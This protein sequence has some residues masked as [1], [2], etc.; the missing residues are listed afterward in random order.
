MYFNKSS[1]IGFSFALALT[2]V[3]CQ[4]NTNIITVKPSPSVSSNPNTESI[5]NLSKEFTSLSTDVLSNSFL[6]NDPNAVPSVQPT[7]S[8]VPTSPSPSSSVSSGSTTDI[9]SLVTLNGTVYNQD[10]IT[11]DNVI[12]SAVSLDPNIKWSSEDKTIGGVY[13]FKN[14]PVGIRVEIT[15]KKGNSIRKK[16]ETLKSNL[17][18]DPSLNKIDF[19]NEY[20]LGVLKLEGSVYDA[21]NKIITS[22]VEVT[23]E[24]LDS[25]NDWTGTATFS[26]GRYTFSEVPDDVR[27]M[28]KVKSGDKE[29]SRIVSFADGKPLYVVNFGG[30]NAEDRVYALANQSDLSAGV[31]LF[32]D[33]KQ[34]NSSS[35]S[36]NVKSDSYYYMKKL[37]NLGTLPSKKDV[38]IEEYINHFDYNY[39]EPN[40]GDSMSLNTE[41]SDSPFGGSG[42]RI[43]RVGVKTK[44]LAA[45]K[46]SNIT[47][48]VDT[49]GSMSEKNKD[50]IIKLS[51]KEAISN[52]SSN[53]KFSIIT[54]DSSSNVLVD[55]LDLSNKDS[56]FDKI[57]NLNFSGNTNAQS[58]IEKALEVSKKNYN[59]DSLNRIILISDGLEDKELQNKNEV[60]N[61]LKDN[62]LNISL[63]TLAILSD[64]KSDLLESVAKSSKGHYSYS[65]TSNEL[66]SNIL[67]NIYDSENIAVRDSNI[68]VNF[69]SSVVKQFRLI[70][71]ENHSTNQSGEPVA[72]SLRNNYSS[73]ALYEIVLNEN[74]TDT[75]IVDVLLSYKDSS[76]KTIKNTIYNTQVRPFNSTSYDF[77]LAVTAGLYAEILRGSYWNLTT[78]LNKVSELSEGLLKESNDNYKVKDFVNLVKKAN[79]L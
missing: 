9:S 5:K 67:T 3:S 13:I 47:F 33:T 58:G 19:N 44:S 56:I 32:I 26:N 23:A 54:Y 62:T 52:M 77:R 49:S 72:Q 28:L 45:S 68:R 22:G 30:V 29:K 11:L 6:V 34:Q 55:N 51:L 75:K 73:T 15:A 8:N 25:N 4:S 41:I 40:T 7:P 59:K 39:K 74:Q 69:N 76:D 35:Y 78:K 50:N 12:V 46:P 63:S 21:N 42:K 43:L 38:K 60:L 70:G 14:A 20:S 37:V 24:S 53:D 1:I 71:Y 61:M 18:G 10:G 16:V 17:T 79:S 57:D 2:L 66:V 48:L 65:N 27:L 36:L 31:N 64:K